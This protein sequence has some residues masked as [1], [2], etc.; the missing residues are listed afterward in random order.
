MTAGG[1]LGLVVLRITAM[2]H[3]TL[4][5]YVNVT[6]GTAGDGGSQ[7]SFTMLPAGLGLTQWMADTAEV[8]VGLLTLVAVVP[9][10]GADLAKFFAILLS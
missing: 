10:L 2:V 3:G 5:N 4:A 1:F 8:Y 7:L 6:N 9:H